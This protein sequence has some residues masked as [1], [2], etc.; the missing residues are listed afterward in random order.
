MKFQRVIIAILA[1]LF[2]ACTPE[3]QPPVPPTSPPA[4]FFT[5]TST[6]Y[7]A[8]PPAPT[9]PPLPTSTTTATPHPIFE[10]ALPPSPTSTPN[11]TE[12]SQQAEI[13]QVLQ[14]YFELR[15]QLLSVSPPSDIRQEV[16]DGL[17]S[18][19]EE[20]KDFL[21]LETAK[22]AVESKWHELN[23][24]RYAKYEYSLEYTDISV[25]AAAQVATVSLHEYFEIICER[26]MES[27]SRNPSACAIGELTHEIVLHNEDGR[28][29]IISDTYWD[30]WWRQFRK[31]ELSTNEILQKIRAKM[32]EL[33][34]RSSPTP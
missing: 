30:A 10:T 25:D 11:A 4:D 3:L 19:G 28:W 34:T 2:A 24:Q 1:M 26:A 17:V 22:L 15:Y 9:L 20:A 27:N 6:L 33:E 29:K 8:A 31:P 7:S 13:K 12:A 32:Q 23:K 21:A 14:A 16:F 5:P 18:G